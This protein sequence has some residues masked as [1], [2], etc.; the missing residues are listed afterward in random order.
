MLY[1]WKYI[2]FTADIE[3][4][5][6]YAVTIGVI[7]AA[8]AAVA[9][10]LRWAWRWFFSSH[11]EESEVQDLAETPPPP[12]QRTRPETYSPS[13]P[14]VDIAIDL[15][16]LSNA[17][18]W[19][20]FHCTAYNA[21]SCT[22]RL[23]SVQGRLRIGPEE[24]HGQFELD[25]LKFIYGTNEFFDFSIKL[26]LSTSEAAYLQKAAEAEHL[27]I[28]FLTTKIE[29]SIHTLPHNSMTEIMVPKTLQFMP[30]DRRVAPAFVHQVRNQRAYFY[31]PVFVVEPTVGAHFSWGGDSG[32][33]VVAEVAPNKMAAV[34]LV[35]AGDTVKG[36]SHVLPLEPILQRFKVGL[37]SG[38]NV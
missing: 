21:T 12:D 23:I 14:L 30:R 20:Q 29:V 28:T 5:Q 34:G 4:W 19:L 17:A 6:V 10:F 18:P 2:Q 13:A 38:H 35:F 9:L 25:N 16:R 8:S 11:S 31:E 3:G 26:A 36:Q 24:F 33:L 7:L 15:G 1:Y 37:L 27:L 22:I 32:S